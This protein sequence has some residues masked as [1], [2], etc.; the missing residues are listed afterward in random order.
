VREQRLDPRPLRI[1]QRHTRTNDQLIQTKL[2]SP[3][4]TIGLRPTG[5]SSV[6]RGG[7]V[8]EFQQQMLMTVL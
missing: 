5:S 4:R 3:A 8:H 2:P 6:A 7:F 1:T